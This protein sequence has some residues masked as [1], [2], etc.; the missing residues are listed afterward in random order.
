MS[1]TPEMVDAM[2]DAGLTREQM[3]ALMK[4]SL[5]AE[6]QKVVEKRA[7]DAARQRKSRVSRNVTVTPCD[8]CDT[9]SPNDALPN[10]ETLEVNLNPTPL[11]VPPQK[12]DFPK[13]AFEQWYAAYPRKVAPKAARKAFVRIERSG[14]VTFAELMAGTGAYARSVV[15]KETAFIA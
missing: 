7:K 14:E 6:E 3:A 15:G 9:P 8:T 2:I 10:L 12:S 11:K 13:D 5:A 4:A 1:L